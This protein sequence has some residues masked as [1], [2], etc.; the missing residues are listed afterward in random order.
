MMW[1]REQDSHPPLS[2]VYYWAPKYFILLKLQNTPGTLSRY[3]KYL[4]VKYGVG[5]E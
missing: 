3:I 4:K 5:T 1:S 2:G